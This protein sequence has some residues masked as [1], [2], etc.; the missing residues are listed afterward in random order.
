MGEGMVV[1]A[2]ISAAFSPAGMGAPAKVAATVEPECAAA[3]M[4][5]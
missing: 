3:G 2:E 5:P 4:F 1:G